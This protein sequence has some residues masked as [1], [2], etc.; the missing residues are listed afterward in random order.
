MAIANQLSRVPQPGGEKVFKNYSV[1]D[2]P[3]GTG[4]L[5]DGTNKGD[6]TQPPGIVTVPTAGSNAKTCGITLEIIK[7]G[8]QGRVV[9]F[10]EAVG[11]SNATLTP[12]ALVK[13]DATAGHEGQ[14]IAASSTDEILGKC[15]T[16]CVAGDPVVVFVAP[17]AHN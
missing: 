8:G 10:G 17:V 16:D 12:G 2:M 13:L 4:V 15:Q 11:V 3:A 1:T 7:A 9:V 5:Y 14:V 6:V